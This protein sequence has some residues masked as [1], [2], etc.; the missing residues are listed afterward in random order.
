MGRGCCGVTLGH[1]L[2]EADYEQGCAV[3]RRSVMSD[4]C[5]P[6][7]CIAHQASLFMGF[8]RQEQEYEQFIRK[9]S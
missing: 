3:L 7:D 1:S 4:S 9:V 8:S 5:D 2:E 6:V